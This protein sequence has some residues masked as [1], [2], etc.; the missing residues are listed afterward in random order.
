MHPSK[1]IC[2]ADC[3]VSIEIGDIFDNHLKDKLMNVHP[4]NFIKSNIVLP[5]YEISIAYDTVNNNRRE[6]KRY[7]IV[8]TPIDE[9]GDQLGF[10][11]FEAE[12]LL[13]QFNTCHPEKQMFNLEIESVEC[14]CELVLQ[15]A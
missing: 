2:D 9:K 4:K 8:N 14:I 7:M 5:L 12:H 3:R 10:I 13:E 1:I 15:I 6:G 11:D